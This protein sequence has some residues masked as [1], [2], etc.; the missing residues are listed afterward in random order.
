M[1]GDTIAYRRVDDVLAEMR[2]NY[3]EKNVRVFNF[4]DDNIAV[5][6]QW[7]KTFLAAVAADETL[8]DI[9][10]TAMNGIGYNLLDTDVL[11][12][13]RRAGFR[14]INLS[15]VTHDPVL[16]RRYHRPGR[17]RN[18]A[19]VIAAARR[20][21]FFITVYVI[22]GLPGQSAAE[23][24]AGI[25]YLLDLGV[26]VGPSVFYIPPG[27]RLYDHLQLP[28]ETVENWNLYRSSAFAVETER[29]TRADLVA[30]FIYTRQRNMENRR[31]GRF[32]RGDC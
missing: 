25:D 20:L 5:N 16:R 23:I 31:R 11:T 29:L 2:K 26:L 12:S 6:R 27:S 28:P 10:M 9:E 4:E 3:R 24:K 18:L 7:F 17:N 19:R 1:F 21:G 22:I 8:G 15:Y 30:L 13:M 14:R 32:N